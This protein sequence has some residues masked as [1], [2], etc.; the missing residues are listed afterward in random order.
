MSIIFEALK[1]TQDS[2]GRQ[3][4]NINFKTSQIEEHKSS[5]QNDPAQPVNKFIIVLVLIFLLSIVILGF[6]LLS[7]L[8]QSKESNL[9]DSVKI[10]AEKNNSG[11]TSILAD[12][13]TVTLKGTMKA[14]DTYVAL[15]DDNIFRVGENVGGMTI[16][17][18][19][20]EEVIL[21]KNG[22]KIFLNVRYKPNL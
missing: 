18:I 10:T 20:D 4:T 7:L 3:Q 17:N 8:N 6:V 15:I 21:E 13:T 16:V 5:P 1:K 2:L 12:G 14:N 19:S 9:R 22:E 11:P